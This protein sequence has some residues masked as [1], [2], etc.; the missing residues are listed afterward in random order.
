MAQNSNIGEKKLLLELSQ[1]SELA[2]T[3]IY[4]QYK[5][6]VYSIA[7]RITKSK[8]LSISFAKRIFALSV[9]STSPGVIITFLPL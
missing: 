6:I 5:D 1:G 9:D 2:F 7:L 3:K 8:T 4:N